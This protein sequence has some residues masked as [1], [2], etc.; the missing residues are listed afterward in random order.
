MS[1]HTR[2]LT[3]AAAG[4]ALLTALSACG[5]G[6]DEP[7][8][9]DGASAS[10]EPSESSSAGA[11]GAAE[12]LADP[13]DDLLDDVERGAVFRGTDQRLTW[14]FPESYETETAQ[15]AQ[16]SDGDGEKSF[17]ITIGSK[18]DTTSQAE[19]ESV[20]EG[21][22]GATVEEV[23]VRGQ[24]FVATAADTEQGSLRTF[25]WTPEGAPITYAVLFYAIG[26][27]VA[28]TPAERLEEVYQTV[29]SLALDGETG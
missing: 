7:S 2:R 19:G 10:S 4:L 16:S 13:G 8:G 11:S 22:D 20:T 12:G 27:S 18:L 1:R 21:M 9:S 6:S 5:S 17:E 3:T 14:S 29:G 23:E 24:P 26:S 28:D 15:Q 25:F